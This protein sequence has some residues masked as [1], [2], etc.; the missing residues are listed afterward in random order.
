MNLKLVGAA[1]L[2]AL[3]VVPAAAEEEVKAKRK[4]KGKRGQQNAA[5]QLLKQLEEVGLTEDQIAKVKELGKTAAAKMK[6][7]RDQAGITLE[8]MK[9]RTEAMKSV[10]DSG[11]KGK[12]AMA[13]A[14]EAAGITEAQE[15][16]LKK[17]AAARMAFQKE[18]MG[19]LTDEQKEKLPER[20]QRASKASG[21][22]GKGAAKKKKDAA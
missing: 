21:K 19:L 13:A 2:V 5:T 4:G 8:V 7:M 18:V 1:L 11:K 10:R 15:A 9:K 20:L 17:I 12:E 16:A 6:E 3:M 14:I 22:K